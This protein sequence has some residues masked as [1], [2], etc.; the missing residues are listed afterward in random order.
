MKVWPSLLSSSEARQGLE[1]FCA[2][3]DQ[4]PTSLGRRENH[5]GSA[6]SMV[7]YGTSTFTFRV[8]PK[9]VFVAACRLSCIA[10]CLH[11]LMCGFTTLSVTG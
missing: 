1:S 8:A 3:W 4:S 2:S 10:A 9:G 6:E 5:S 7:S 11:S